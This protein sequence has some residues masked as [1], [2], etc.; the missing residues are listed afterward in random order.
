LEGLILLLPKRTGFF[1]SLLGIGHPDALSHYMAE[2]RA[3]P[4]PEGVRRR[5]G[6]NHYPCN[7]TIKPKCFWAL[8]LFQLADI[9]TDRSD[10]IQ[11]RQEF[12]SLKMRE[13]LKPISKDPQR[14][15][16][17]LERE[18]IY[19][20][21]KKRC[22]KCGAEVIWSEGEIHHIDEH[23]KGGMTIL[24][25][26]ALVHRHCH[27]KGARAVEFAKEWRTRIKRTGSGAPP[28]VSHGDS[29]ADEEDEENG[30][31]T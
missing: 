28:V 8:S 11:R 16:G 10:A 2:M 3:G 29:D 14:Q 22:A 5:R 19:Y 26:G 31:S 4:P 20:R 21:D 1:N 23:A 15:F 30:D 18:L 27:P 17:A 24:E 25:N 6:S 9:T 13:I 7:T 12:F